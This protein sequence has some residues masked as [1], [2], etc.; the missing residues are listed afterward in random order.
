MTNHRGDN[1]SEAPKRK[2]IE[3]ALPLETINRES[4]RE[5]SIRHG[6]P[7][8]LHLW[9][10]R[11][12]LATVRAVLFAQLVDDP[13]SHPDRFPTE[14]TQ[15]AERERLHQIIEQLVV[16][17]NTRDKA[18]LAEAHAEILRSTGGKPPPILDP[19]A[20][21]AT[22]PLEAQRL[23][24]EAHASDLNPVA[25]LINKA[26]V[27]IPPTFAGQPPVFPGLAESRI[28]DWEGATGL[29][30]DVR[31]YGEWMRD[32][33][34]TRIG[35][36]YPQA[37]LEHGTKATVIAWIWARA[38]T[39]PNPACG[40]EMPLTSKWWLGKKKGKEAWIRPL[41]VADSGHPSGK[42]VEFEIGHGMAG[43]GEDGTIGRNGATCLSCGAAVGLDY[44]RARSREV[45]LGAQLMAI[46][47]EGNRGRVYLPPNDEHRRAAEVPRPESAPEASLPTAAIGFRVQN[48][49]LTRWADLF[50]NRQLL[51]LTTFSDLV[52]EARERVLS[53]AL[54]ISIPQGDHVHAAGANAEAYADA[55]ATFLGMA[56]SRYANFMNALCQWRPDAGKEQVG[57]LFSRQAIPM[58]WD[59]AEANFESNSAGGWLPTLKFIPKALVVHPADPCTYASRTLPA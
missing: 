25:V 14:D 32:E 48:Y 51:A 47:T 46:A 4:A 59:F 55:I 58:A 23:G 45:G 37:T 5:K 12:P 15:R 33:A 54:A 57:H 9:W 39:C 53:D 27:E 2:L 22:I 11:K 6:H 30:A 13:S 3:V 20:G 7:S 50:T 26:L 52:I 42:R 17:E 19:F 44:V 16:W 34:E 49:G 28:G 40:I 35:T 38:V 24:L 21:G 10:S 56:V 41:I 36:H 18:L 43:A 8:T 31:A 29:A 1:A